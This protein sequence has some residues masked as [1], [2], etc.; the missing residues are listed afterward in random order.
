MYFRQ[1]QHNKHLHALRWLQWNVWMTIKNW[2]IRW[3]LGG[4]NCAINVGM[5]CNPNIWVLL[6]FCKNVKLSLC[7]Y[8]LVNSEQLQSLL[9]S[10]LNNYP[11][12][13][14]IHS[15][16]LSYLWNSI[17]KWLQVLLPWYRF[18]ASFMLLKIIVKILVQWHD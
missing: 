5:I 9:G 12:L 7:N 6:V 4:I 14:P 18:C 2:Y 8:S 10:L 1:Q 13:R 11:L 16:L 15:F 3:F 17:V